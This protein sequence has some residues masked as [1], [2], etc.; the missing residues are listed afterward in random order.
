M[1]RQC[2]REGQKRVKDVVERHEQSVRNHK[3]GGFCGML[4]LRERGIRTYFAF[5][6]SP[7]V[8]EPVSLDVEIA[9]DDD[10]VRYIGAHHM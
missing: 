8:Y 6:V 10:F 1:F 7:N 2:T 5:F 9:R 3:F 4:L